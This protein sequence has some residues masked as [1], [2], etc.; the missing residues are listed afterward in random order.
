MVINHLLTGRILQVGAHFIPG[1]QPLRCH[2]FPST[3]YPLKP[4]SHSC[5]KKGTFLG[6]TGR[7]LFLFPK[8][9]TPFFRLQPFVFFVSCF[10][11]VYYDCQGFVVVGGLMQWLSQTDLHANRKKERKKERVVDCFKRRGHLKTP[12]KKRTSQWK[13]TWCLIGDTSSWFSWWFQPIWKIFPSHPEWL[14]MRCLC[15]RYPL[16]NI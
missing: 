15:W 3:C 9:N 11:C 16:R 1:K 5:L 14:L 7:W 6:F 4:A 12:G 8:N 13:I 2:K 10:G